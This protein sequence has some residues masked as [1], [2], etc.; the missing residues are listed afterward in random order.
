MLYKIKRKLFQFWIKITNNPRPSSY[1][2]ISSDS[3]RALADH[4]FDSHNTFNPENVKAGDIVSVGN[5]S[6]NRYIETI[7]PRIK[8]K[9]V[10]IGLNEN[11]SHGEEL[12]KKLDEKIIRLYIEDV[13]YKNEKIIPVP[14][15]LESLHI[16][17]NGVNSLFDKLIKKIKKTPPK[18][19][20]RIFFYFSVDTNP[21]ERGPTKK[22]FLQHPLAETVEKFLP[23]HLHLRKIIDY[24]LIASPPGRTVESS[25]T[26]EALYLKT[27]PIVKDFSCMQYFKSLGLPIWIVKDWHEL[28]GITEGDISKKYNE[29]ISAANFESLYMDFWI[30]KIKED[31][32][33]AKQTPRV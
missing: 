16:H 17:V 25:R 14:I 31:Q 24:K 30:K 12:A 11:T 1:P 10:L 19:K 9:Y 23:S 6:M 15:G 21:E 20:N 5:D 2:Y 26:W 28:D 32:S 18:R 8:Q 13:V 29:L 27:V 3:F 7:H 22:Y 33:I 4:I